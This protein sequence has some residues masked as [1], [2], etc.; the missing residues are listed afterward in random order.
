MIIPGYDNQ[1]RAE[2]CLFTWGGKEF[3]WG[4]KEIITDLE[5]MC[6][7]YKHKKTHFFY[8]SG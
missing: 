5:N 4:V 8:N 1:G 2:D 6:I 7:K 3:I